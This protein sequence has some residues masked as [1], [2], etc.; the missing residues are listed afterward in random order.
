MRILPFFLAVCVGGAHRTAPE[1]QQLGIIREE[2]LPDCQE[3]VVRPVLLHDNTQNGRLVQ[4]GIV[5][6]P[7]DDPAAVAREACAATESQQADCVGAVVAE[8]ASRDYM[9]RFHAAASGP[10][11]VS[12]TA[13]SRHEKLTIV[14][15]LRAFERPRRLLV[16][17]A[18]P[19]AAAEIG[20]KHTKRTMPW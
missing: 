9:A 10:T 13:M 16:I 17:G 15:R 4:T 12:P 11:R 3:C 1:E 20:R 19:E 2:P 14:K 6:H 18:G 5:L 7:G 8:I